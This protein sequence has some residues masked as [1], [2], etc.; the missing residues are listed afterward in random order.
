MS[1]TGCEPMTAALTSL[2]T[3]PEVAAA[4]R[5]LCAQGASIEA[6][7]DSIL[8]AAEPGTA[9]DV[10]AEFRELPRVTAGMILQAWQL[11]DGAGKPFELVSRRPAA[12]LEFARE[13]RVRITLDAE[14]E[15]VR[16]A[17][18]HVPGRHASWYAPQS[19]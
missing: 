13:R 11:A 16:V 19:S 14:S 8:S 9:A 7:I 4:L 6:Q 2:L 5:A 18:S 3:R 12:P 15:V 17:L 1:A 10:L